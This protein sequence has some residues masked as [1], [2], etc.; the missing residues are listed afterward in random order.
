M[1]S[2]ASGHRDIDRRHRASPN[3]RAVT[4]TASASLSLVSCSVL[5]SISQRRS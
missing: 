3:P 5:R 2:L 4:A 1:L